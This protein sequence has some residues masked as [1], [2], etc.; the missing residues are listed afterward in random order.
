MFSFAD[1][2]FINLA[3]LNKS[4][5]VFHLFIMTLV[6]TNP[7][8]GTWLVSRW[9]TTPQ[10][11]ALLSL[12]LPIQHLWQSLIIPLTWY[13]DLCLPF[14]TLFSLPKMCSPN[15]SNWLNP[16]H[17]SRCNVALPRTGCLKRTLLV[18]YVITLLVELSYSIQT[19]FILLSLNH[20]L[21]KGFLLSLEASWG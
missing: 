9:R 1:D 10:Y 18:V 7:F 17:L 2:S 15:L 11:T 13:V 20:V 5:W 21:L 8:Q 16:T 3:V 19:Y 4:F 12:S 6:F 14:G